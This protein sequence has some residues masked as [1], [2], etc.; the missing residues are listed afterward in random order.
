MYQRPLGMEIRD[1]DFEQ[2]QFQINHQQQE[3][4]GFLNHNAGE[5]YD[6]NQSLYENQQQRFNT[7]QAMTLAPLAIQYIPEKKERTF[8]GSVKDEDS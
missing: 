8:M 2:H 5:G 7:E 3:N 1:S 4:S 6:N